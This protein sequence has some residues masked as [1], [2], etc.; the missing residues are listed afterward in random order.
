MT[1]D[2]LKKEAAGEGGEGKTFNK[3]APE[4]ASQETDMKLIE[5]AET[6]AYADKAM[7]LLH[8]P[9]TPSSLE[10]LWKH[11][12]SEVHPMLGTIGPKEKGQFKHFRNACPPDAAD[13]VMTWVLNDWSHFSYK[14]SQGAGVKHAPTLPNLGFLLRHVKI[15]VTYWAISKSPKKQEAKPAIPVDKTVQLT[16]LASKHNVMSWEELLADPDE[17]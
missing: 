10:T 14:V 5:W 6:K 11:K 1:G 4:I 16:S 3:D 8:K 7:K 15:A 2:F 17:G 9:N 12:V 13:E